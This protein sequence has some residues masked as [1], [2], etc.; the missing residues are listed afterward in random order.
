MIAPTFITEYEKAMSDE[1]CDYMIAMADRIKDQEPSGSSATVTDHGVTRNDWFVY[2]GLTNA[3]A[4]R[5][6]NSVL[7]SCLD[8]YIQ[9]YNGISYCARFMSFVQKLQVTEPGGGF[10]QW[11]AENTS[12]DYSDRILT[13]MI[14]LNDMP[15]G[16]A[17]TEFLHQRVRFKPKKGS[18]LLWP[19]G[20]TH[21]HRGN[22]PLTKTKYI[23]TGW[24]NLAQG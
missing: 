17:E 11:H 19:A 5:E 21:T 24:Y 8:Q 1:T 12:A 4:S 16:E 20:W 14:Y 3:Q 2:V 23:V 22:P 15:D 13:W 18:V 10:H 9:E 7:Q 6:I